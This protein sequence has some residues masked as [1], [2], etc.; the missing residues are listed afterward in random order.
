MSQAANT[1]Y[2]GPTSGSPASPTFRTIVPNDLVG[3]MGNTPIAPANS[4]TAIPL[5][6]LLGTHLDIRTFGAQMNAQM[7]WPQVTVA[8]GSFTYQFSSGIF[9]STDV[10]KAIQ[11]NGAGPSGQPVSATITGFISSTQLT[12][13]IAASLSLTAL[14]Q[15]VFWGTDDS[16]ALAAAVMEAQTLFNSG[17]FCYVYIPPG[18]VYIKSTT[19]PVISQAPIP[20]IGAGAQITKLIV[21]PAYPGTSLFSWSLCWDENSFSGSSTWDSASTAGPRCEGIG[22]IGN[23]LSPASIIAINLLDIDDFVRLVDLQFDFWPGTVIATGNLHASGNNYGI[24]RESRITEI[25]AFNCGFLNGSTNSPVILI[26][27]VGNSDAT[28]ELIFSSIDIFNSK[29]DGFVIINNNP[30]GSTRLIRIFGIRVD[31][32][33][34]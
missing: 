5:S 6:Q 20:I 22:F 27:S 34:G 21:D 29:A 19:M 7:A 10:G 3:S 30:A 12:L 33:L 26:N 17:S 15:P 14:V 4:S 25:R 28:N 18:L 8:S 9:H 11:V 23:E 31:L 1:F 32:V 16:A 24:I 2:A 13:S